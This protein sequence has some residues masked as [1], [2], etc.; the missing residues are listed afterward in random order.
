MTAK[1]RAI[2]FT[3]GEREEWF[4]QKRWFGLFWFDVLWLIGPDT[5]DR[6]RF[7]TEDAANK[8][9]ANK[10]ELSELRWSPIRRSQT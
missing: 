8:W 5:Y 4:V 9:I 3:N 6:L 1:Y 10:I 7:S 2:G